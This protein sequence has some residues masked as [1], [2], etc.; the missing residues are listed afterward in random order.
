MNDMS[1]IIKSDKSR[2][3]EDLSEVE[4]VRKGKRMRW[5]ENSLSFVE[6]KSKKKRKELKRKMFLLYHYSIIICIF[7]CRLFITI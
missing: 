6:K 1:D 3:V 4:I 2:F 7:A 5:D